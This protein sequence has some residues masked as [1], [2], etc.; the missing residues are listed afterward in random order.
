MV[1]K[2]FIASSMGVVLPV[3]PTKIMEFF[4]RA[5]SLRPR[6]RL[7]GFRRPREKLRLTGRRLAGF[8]RARLRDLGD[9]FLDDGLAERRKVFRHNDKG[10]GAADDMSAVVIIETAL[11]IGVVGI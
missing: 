3:L 10:A 4:F 11:R 8:C 5:Q 7:L 2:I 1:S 9:Q 6:D